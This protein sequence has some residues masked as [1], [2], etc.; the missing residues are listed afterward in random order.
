MYNM[1]IMIMNLH[2]GMKRRC[3]YDGYIRCKS[4]G[5]CLHSSY[6]CNGYVNCPDGSDEEN[7]GA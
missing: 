4:T 6:I 2:I 7:C 3:P 1:I 5:H